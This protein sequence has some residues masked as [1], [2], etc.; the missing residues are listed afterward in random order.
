MQSDGN[1]V[2]YDQFNRAHWATGTNGRGGTRVVLQDDGNL[3]IYTSGGSPVWASN[4]WHDW[5]PVSTN[6]DNLHLDTGE[7]MSSV[8]SISSSGLISGHTRIWTTNELSGF[9]GSAFPVLL[10]SA[11]NI[12]WPSNIDAAKHQYGVDGTWVPGLPSDRTCYWTNQVDAATLAQ[13]RGIGLIQYKDPKNMLMRDLDI[14]KK[15]YDVVGPIVA[16]FAA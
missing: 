4:T 11:D 14:I 12:I 9:H 6:T 3:V 13:S 8:A 15:V 16:A 2:C 1:F 5:S 7:W 10:D